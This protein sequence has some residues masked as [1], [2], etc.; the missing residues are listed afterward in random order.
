MTQAVLTVYLAS[1]QGRVLVEG[2]LSQHEGS[3]LYTALSCHKSLPW[4][5]S[6]LQTKQ[7]NCQLASANCWSANGSILDCLSWLFESVT[8]PK[9]EELLQLP[10]N[11]V[12]S[13]M[14]RESTKGQNTTLKRTLNSSL[15]SHSQTA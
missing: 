14:I 7:A 5:G 6:E 4:V 15:V 2:L 1:F 8:R 12:G 13:F 10:G 9:A 11:R 3:E